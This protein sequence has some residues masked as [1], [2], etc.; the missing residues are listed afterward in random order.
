[1]QPLSDQSL[2]DS[3]W[4]LI[5]HLLDNHKF[6]VADSLVSAVSLDDITKRPMSQMVLEATNK[7]RELA[8]IKAANAFNAHLMGL[9]PFLSSGLVERLSI[10]HLVFPA[11]CVCA[12]FSDEDEQTD[13][14]KITLMHN[15]KEYTFRF[16]YNPQW[17]LSFYIRDNPNFDGEAFRKRNAKISDKTFTSPESVYRHFSSQNADDPLLGFVVFLV[18]YVIHN[19]SVLSSLDLKSTIRKGE[20]HHESQSIIDSLLR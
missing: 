16:E 18:Y 3:T 13:V 19:R 10:I 7:D 5:K 4:V 8:Y 2:I 14:I 20:K 15:R 1:M 17:G 11:W 12:S 9:F 6:A